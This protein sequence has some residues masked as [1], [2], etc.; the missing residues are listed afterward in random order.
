MPLEIAGKLP[1]LAG[2]DAFLEVLGH[3]VHVAQ[4]SVGKVCGGRVSAVWF[5]S[6]LEIYSSTLEPF[7]LTDATL[8]RTRALEFIGQLD[9]L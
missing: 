8:C 9:L 6:S 1:E 5:G 4:L 3:S 7:E 2:V